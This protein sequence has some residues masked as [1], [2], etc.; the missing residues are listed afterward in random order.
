MVDLGDLQKGEKVR[1]RIV[2]ELEMRKAFR[3]FLYGAGENNAVEMK[4]FR[5]F[6]CI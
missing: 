3:K 6:A 1:V 4:K 2:G 5:H